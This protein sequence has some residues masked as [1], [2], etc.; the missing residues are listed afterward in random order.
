M[1]KHRQYPRQTAQQ[2]N[3]QGMGKCWAGCD[4][5]AKVITLTDEGGYMLCFECHERHREIHEQFDYDMEPSEDDMAFLERIAAS[6]SSDGPI[7]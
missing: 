6:M 5:D 1:S 2:Q 7:E 4:Q 3:K